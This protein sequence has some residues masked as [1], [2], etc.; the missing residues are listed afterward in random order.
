ML[1]VV[2]QRRVRRVTSDM[3]RALDGKMIA[4]L[5]FLEWFRRGLILSSRA[6]VRRAGVDSMQM[7]AL[8]HTLKDKL[9]RRRLEQE[10][11]KFR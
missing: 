10:R 3:H 5:N 6:D 2:R 1:V 4:N 7:R 11:R 9:M 8:L